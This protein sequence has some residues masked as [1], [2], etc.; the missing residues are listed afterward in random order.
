MG[1]KRTGPKAL[2]PASKSPDAIRLLADLRELID[3]ARDQVA[4]AVN[5]SLTLLYWAVGERIR[6]E[7]LGEQRAEYGEQIV[8]TVSRQLT[9]DSGRGF[10]TKALW[11]MIQFAE[12]FPD[13]P[14]VQTLAGQLGWSHF[15]E[16]IPLQD[17]LRR[18]FYAEMCRLERWSV[19]TLRERI[20]G[21]LYERTAI[22]RKPDEQIRQELTRLRDEDR[23]TPDL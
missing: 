10:T 2:V 13:R 6:R 19:R 11:R 18:D 22:A 23:L 16:I 20:A 7:I 5:A 17:Q 9:G 15:V 8:A 3:A 4:R 12:V 14:V 21:K 1:K